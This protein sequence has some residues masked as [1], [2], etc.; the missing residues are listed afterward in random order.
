VCLLL[1]GNSTV[2]ALYLWDAL[3]DDAQVTADGSGFRGVTLSYIVRSQERVEA[4]L[5]EAERAGARS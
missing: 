3:A 4:V 1:G 2:L 5:S